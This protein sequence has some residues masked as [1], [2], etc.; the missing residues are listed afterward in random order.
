ML[1]IYLQ[2]LEPRFLHPYSLD[3]LSLNYQLKTVSIQ[4]SSSARNF[5]F[6]SAMASTMVEYSIL[7]VMLL[8]AVVVAASALSVTNT[9][10]RTT[11]VV[12]NIPILPNTS[13]NLNGPLPLPSLLPTVLNISALGRSAAVVVPAL[14]QQVYITANALFGIASGLLNQVLGVIPVP[15]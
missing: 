5:N 10:P 1:W 4:N 8:L 14:T 12:N 11:I 6:L 7:K 15:V 2:H 3:P 9:S 13:V